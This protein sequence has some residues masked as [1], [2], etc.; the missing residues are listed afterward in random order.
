MLLAAKM[1]GIY[2]KLH[3]VASSNISKYI[4]NEAN[5]KFLNQYS[6]KDFEL[7]LIMMTLS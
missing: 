7:K 1:I 4:P 3:G 5:I 6:L 2:S